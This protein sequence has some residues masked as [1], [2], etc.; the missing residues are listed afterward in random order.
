MY[1]QVFKVYYIVF[2]YNMKFVKYSTSLCLPTRTLTYIYEQ[3]YHILYCNYPHG[4]PA[5]NGFLYTIFNNMK[6][7]SLLHVKN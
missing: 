2:T 3:L 4:D 1:V 7:H 6:N 5:P